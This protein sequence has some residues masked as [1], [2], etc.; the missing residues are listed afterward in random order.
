VN[1]TLEPAGDSWRIVFVRQ[2]GH[3]ADKVWRAVTQLPHLKAWFPQPI[4]GEFVAGGQL[5]FHAGLAGVGDFHGIVLAAEPPRLLE[6]TWGED[7]LRI[8]IEPDGGG[9]VLTF[10]D[11]ITDLGK[12]ARDGA[13]WHVCLDGLE[14][15]LDG[16]PAPTMPDSWQAIHP[17]Y[18]SEFGP[19]AS[20]IGPPK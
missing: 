14:A 8:V 3:P 6:F 5:T 15:D 12:A 1:G 7:T 17:S 2:L 13:G 19:A 4:S 9:C 10:S 18:V 16:A 11:T 20:T